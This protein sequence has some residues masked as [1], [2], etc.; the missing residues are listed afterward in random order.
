E[1]CPS[2]RK[3]AAISSEFS[4]QDL[5]PLAFNKLSGKPL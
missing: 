4:K 2:P 1:N 3:A 5:A